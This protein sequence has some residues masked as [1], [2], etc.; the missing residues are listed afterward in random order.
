MSETRRVIDRKW[1]VMITVSM[2]VLLATIDGSIVN[3]ALPRLVE[4]LDTTFP[5]IQWVAL[6]YLLTLATLTLGVGRAGDVLGKKRI[7]VVGFALFTAASVLCGLAPSV[8]ILIGVRVLQALGAVMVLSLGPAVLVEAFPASE[9]GKALGLIGTAVSLGI[10]TGPVVGGLLISSFGWRSI[11]FVNLPVGIVGTFLA[12][13]HVPHTL[14]GGRQRFDYV[15]AA[16]LS[17]SL[18]ALSLGLTLG[19][20]RGF[21]DAVV[22]AL[23]ASAF[24]TGGL[25]VRV[26]LR[27]AS[28][29]IQLRMFRSTLLS[30]SVVTGYLLFVVLAGTFFLLPFYLEEV[31]GRP[32]DQ[33]GLLLGA[34][35]LMLGLVS[36]FSGSWSDRIGVRPL[37]VTGLVI[38][39]VSYAAFL[40]LSVD[41]SAFHFVVLA[42][43][44]GIGMGIFQSPNNSAI[45]GSVPA[46]YAG[47]GGGLLNLTRLLGQITG[48]A[49]LGSVWAA[50]V[51]AAGGPSDAAEATPAQQMSGLTDVIVVMA[52]IASVAAM[53]SAYALMRERR[54][55]L[56]ADAQPARLD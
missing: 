56:G 45:M 16:L 23:G 39:A 54:S 37:A 12:I 22:L 24:A 2:G 43:P 47:V 17:A 8:Q 31:Q 6:G 9:R 18:L 5:V 55:H 14:P 3:V 28:P 50:R 27:S 1:L 32:I 42:V 21:A 15:G 38:A 13:R 4:D 53:V 40:T 34:A 10:V 33:V 44:L 35:P 30:V 25:F 19:Q 36:P 29:M 7:Y 11:F 48:I 49:V 26:E 52:V 46:A 51:A 20:E 41:T